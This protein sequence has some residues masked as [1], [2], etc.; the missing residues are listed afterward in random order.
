MVLDETQQAVARWSPDDGN[1][2][3]VGGAGAGKT[4][5]LA[6]LVAKLVLID[7]IPPKDICVMAFNRDAAQEISDRIKK[8]IGS[9]HA[10]QMPVGTFHSLGRRW[11]DRTYPGQWQMERC[12]DIPRKSRASGVPS[13]SML[14][15]HAVTFGAMPGTGCRTLGVSQEAYRYEQQV[16][17]MRADGIKASDRPTSSLRF[18]ADAWEMV[19]EAKQALQVW[20]FNDVLEAWLDVLRTR[21]EGWMRVVIVDEAQD[22]TRVRLDIARALAGTDGRMVLVGDLRQTI[23]LWAGAYPDLFQNADVT[24]DAKTLCLGY[25][26]RSIPAIVALSNE[27]ARDKAWLL[28]DE[29]E[30]SREEVSPV[31]PPSGYGTASSMYSA[32]AAEVLA[33]HE[34]NPD[35]TRAV[36]LRTNGMIAQ[37]AAE[38]QVRNIPVV[39]QGSRP[40]FET[41]EGKTILD[42][43]RAI[44]RN[45]LEAFARVLNQPNRFASRAYQN[46]LAIQ[47]LSEDQPVEEA[48]MPAAQRCRVAPRTMQNLRAFGH[49]MGR[50]RGM[51]WE[52]AMSQIGTTI[53]RGWV[54][55]GAAHETDSAAVLFAVTELARRFEGPEEFLT[56]VDPDLREAPVAMNPVVLSTIHRAKGREWDMVFVDVSRGSLPYETG[57][58]RSAAEQQEEERLLYVAM[59]RARTMLHLGYGQ[60]LSP[61]CEPLWPEDDLPPEM[62]PE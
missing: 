38:F 41:N 54:D 49:A 33:D 13:T 37:C 8:M 28:G 17:L 55:T 48:L 58:P 44:W 24:L 47:F 2:R 18:L 61:L 23:Y 42:Y 16:N 7:E 3:V 43:V 34:L 57:H 5:T 4:G 36:L 19:E 56:F 46:Q 25:N 62:P 59:T 60:E 21:P 9:Q 51:A 6:T 35:N 14:W 11:L 1:L 39:V 22:N 26:Y 10:D 15:R 50:W 30:A 45:D 29:P 53:A 31:L 27:Y 40:L 12:T 52:S 20:D 32:W